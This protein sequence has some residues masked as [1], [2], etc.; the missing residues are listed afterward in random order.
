MMKHVCTINKG[1]V[2]YG[3]DQWYYQTTQWTT[4]I[5]HKCSK[6]KRVEELWQCPVLLQNY[7][8]EQYDET[9]VHHT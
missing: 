6:H 3:C 7:T 1:V 5:K 2:D 4:I 8:D 9:C